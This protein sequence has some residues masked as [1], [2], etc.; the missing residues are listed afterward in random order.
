MEVCTKAFVEVTRVMEAV[1]DDP[2]QMIL[3]I[4]T[5]LHKE[6]H[7]IYMHTSTVCFLLKEIRHQKDDNIK[8]V[9]K[10]FIK[11]C[12]SFK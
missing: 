5:F 2:F 11:V 4:E 12:V 8:Y 9:S 1:G 10:F 6:K 7:N 3:K